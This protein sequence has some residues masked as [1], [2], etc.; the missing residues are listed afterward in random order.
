MSVLNKLAHFQNRRDEAPNQALAREL[1]EKKDRAGVREIARNLWNENRDVQSDCLKVLYEVG[2]LDP[3]L[4]AAYAGDFL[5]LLKSRNNRLVWGSMTALAAIA[6]IKAAEI[7]AH[8]VLSACLKRAWP[9]CAVHG[10]RA[11]KR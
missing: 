6:E 7:Y 9:I 4:I 3:R 10:R 11:S 8:P 1:A 5:K 2:S